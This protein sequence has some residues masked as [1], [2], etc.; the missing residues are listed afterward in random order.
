MAAGLVTRSANRQATIV[1]GTLLDTQ[2][3]NTNGQ[4]F[5]MEHTRPFSYTVRGVFNGC[6]VT[7]YVSDQIVQPSN[8]DNNQA[9][10]AIFTAPGS[11]GSDY[12]FNWI[13][14]VVTNAGA[15]TS[16]T[17]DVQGG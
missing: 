6:T 14:A 13:K 5:S 12:S 8:S 10:H 4:W 16:I 7:V 15:S 17:V 11:N 2:T 3:T 9:Q 1:S